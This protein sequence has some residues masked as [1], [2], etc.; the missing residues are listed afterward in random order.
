MFQRKNQDILS[1]HYN[2]LVDF[3]NDTIG[4]DDD[5]E[6][7]MTIR[8]KDH[9]LESEPEEEIKELVSEN[10]SKRQANMTKKHV[11]KKMAKGERI[12]FDDEGN[13]SIFIMF[14]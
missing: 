4:K 9:E 14:I 13:V 5:D 10:L 6:D 2:K 12:V 8:R 1:E 11:A 7:F 3:E